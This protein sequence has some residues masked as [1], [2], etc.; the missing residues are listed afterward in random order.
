MRGNEEE[1]ETIT[2]AE[3]MRRQYNIQNI[4][5]GQPLLVNVD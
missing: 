3:H 5:M 1:L 2:V 4:E